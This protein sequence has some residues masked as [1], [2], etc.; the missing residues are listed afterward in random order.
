MMASGGAEPDYPPAAGDDC[1]LPFTLVRSGAI[2][3]VVR[4]GALAD[5]VLGHH[6]YPDPVAAS[7]GE[8]LALTAMLGSALKHEG[9][10]ILQTR[11]DGALRFLVVNHEQRPAEDLQASTSSRSISVAA[12]Q[13]AATTRRNC[14]VRFKVK[15]MLADGARWLSS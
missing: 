12:G 15:V 8:A 5:G 10:L 3:Q 7:L 14:G 11:T 6:D 1:V 4:L 9:K 2:G 13:K